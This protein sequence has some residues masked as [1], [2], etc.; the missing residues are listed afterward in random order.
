MFF[1]DQA[2]A[3]YLSV[4]CGHGAAQYPVEFRL[5]EQEAG[6]A[7]LGGRPEVHRLA[8][9]VFDNPHDYRGRDGGLLADAEAV[10]DGVRSWRATRT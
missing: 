4:L 7:N 6:L 5:N 8:R 1:R 9:T 10:D 3:L 2:G